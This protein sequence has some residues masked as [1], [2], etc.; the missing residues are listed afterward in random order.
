MIKAIVEG[1]GKHGFEVVQ[2]ISEGTFSRVYRVL[3]EDGYSKVVKV[4]LHHEELDDLV[5]KNIYRITK[6]WSSEQITR[7]E[8]EMLSQLNSSY[9]LKP[10]RMLKGFDS[11][12][13]WGLVLENVQNAI[14]MRELIDAVRGLTG[15]EGRCQSAGWLQLARGFPGLFSGIQSYAGSAVSELEAHQQ[16]IKEVGPENQWKV[17]SISKIIFNGVLNRLA[18]LAHQLQIAVRH[19]IGSGVVHNDIKPENILIDSLSTAKLIDYGIAYR[20]ES[21][22][23]FWGNSLYSPPERY[24]DMPNGHV[25][26]WALMHIVHQLLMG[27]HYYEDIDQ[28]LADAEII[29]ITKSYSKYSGRDSL[30]LPFSFPK[31]FLGPAAFL[32]R[33]E[34]PVKPF[35]FQGQEA[36]LSMDSWYQSI[37]NAYSEL[38]ELV[39]GL[40][41]NPVHRNPKMPKNS[42]SS[43]VWDIKRFEHAIEENSPEVTCYSLDSIR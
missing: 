11:D 37:S 3:T 41:I 16:L 5:S 7:N 17:A 29:E 30:I 38:G 25:D 18:M 8:G 27:R 1:L 33:F 12:D 36:G 9:I 26:L 13:H 20:V 15:P 4:N 14:T 42:L 40:S 19:Q 39:W 32:A 2:A 34:P 10:D 35:A 22:N 43:L 31:S 23:G 21:P 24:V 6:K 28:T